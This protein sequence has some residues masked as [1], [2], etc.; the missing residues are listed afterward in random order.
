MQRTTEPF[1]LTLALAYSIIK[2]FCG[3]SDFG[4][5]YKS[6]SN[7]ASACRHQ[8]QENIWSDKLKFLPGSRVSQKL[9]T[10]WM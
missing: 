9:K 10:T 6:F 4:I 7:S 5:C 2:V 8:T 1:P 3:D